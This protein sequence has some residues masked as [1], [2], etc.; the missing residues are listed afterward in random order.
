MRR[1]FRRGPDSILWM[2]TAGHLSKKKEKNSFLK[3]KFFWKKRIESI[4]EISDRS[5]SLIGFTERLGAVITFF[6]SLLK[7]QSW[8]CEKS[9]TLPDKQTGNER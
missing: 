9:R 3:N 8:P 6:F 4:T 1:E 5:C 7:C 2:A